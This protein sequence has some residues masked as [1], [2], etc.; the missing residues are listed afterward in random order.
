MLKPYFFLF[1]FL[2]THLLNAQHNWVQ[3]NP[4]GG[5]AIAMV[6]ATAD[7]AIVA[8]SDLSGIYIS[9]NNGTSWEVKGATQ[10]LTET[11]ISALG[12]HPTDGNTFIIG[13]GG[14]A[15]KTTDGGNTIYPVNIEVSPNLGI[16]YVE[17]IGMAFSDA[18]IG[19]MAH[20]EW[21]EPIL[22]FLKTT[23][24]GE[25]W[26][27]VAHDLPTDTRIVKILVDK[28]NAN[29]VYALCGRARFGCTD[30]YLFK[31]SNGGQNWTRVATDVG[32]ILDIDLHPTDP[33]IIYVTNFEI[34]N[35]PCSVELWQYPT[36]VGYLFKST[37]GG[38]NFTQIADYGGIISV[39]TDPNHITVTDIIAPA[40][41]NDIAGTWTTDNGGGSWTHTGFVQDWSYGWTPLSFAYALSFNGLNKTLVKDQFNPD[42]LYASFGQWAWSSI[43]GGNN[44]LNIS[45]QSLGNNEYISTGLENI[46]NNAMDVNDS[47]PNIVYAG[48][49]DIGFWYSKNHG[50]SWTKSY[51]DK[52][53][54]SD[55][56]WWDGGG[57]NLNFVLSDP[58]RPHV[59]WAMF[60]AGNASIVGTFFKS[61][62]YGENWN[63]SNNGLPILKNMHGI[64][65]DYNSPV[66]NRTLYLTNDGDVYKSVDD[67]ANWANVLTNGGLKFTEVDRFNS[68]LIYAGGENGFWRSIDAGQNWAE[69]GLSEMRFS[70]YIDNAVMRDDIVPTFD[71]PWDNPPVI[72]WQGIFDIEADPTVPNRVYATAYGPEKGL[73][74]S[75][76]AGQNWTKLYTNDKMR[77]VSVAPQN[78][79]VIYLSSSLSYHSGGWSDQSKGFLQSIDGGITWIDINDGMAWTNGGRLE[80]E[81]GAHPYVW[82]SSPGTGLQRAQIPF[83]TSIEDRNTTENTSISPNPFT[84]EFTLDG[85]FFNSKIKITDILG[86]LIY[87]HPEASGP[88]VIDSKIWIPGIYFISITN[89]KGAQTNVYKV[90]KE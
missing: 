73:Y 67:G 3:T 90:I 57:T 14:G 1:V 28:N 10:G 65:I 68:S 29:L 8:A 42:R 58:E 39:G 13:T 12:F 37:D 23:D 2:L 80:V 46:V 62:E 82:G 75:D 89:R 87:D 11:H 27:K 18:T 64:S 41:W 9:H 55:Y 81:H 21:W 25:N 33:N 22:S 60:G 88:L 20:Y 51:P 69:V 77:C 86:R 36:D 49:Y 61:T 38:A 54:Y 30:P 53:L 56:V 50:E 83:F 66:N 4:G 84:D 74:R 19:Y 72:A 16:G 70:S 32:A 71:V 7:G 6:G 76:D 34:A 31:S 78:S 47:D 40:D 35:N 43:D 79:D 5:G 44:L 63:I 59:V 15:F 85:D 17:S 45:T 48:Y 26:T 52:D 24:G